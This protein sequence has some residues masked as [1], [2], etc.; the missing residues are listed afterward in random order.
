MAGVMAGD[1]LPLGGAGLGDGPLDTTCDRS[2]VRGG[3]EVRCGSFDFCG[4]LG[5][6]LGSFWARVAV[7][8]GLRS[9]WVGRGFGEGAAA[10]IG[11]LGTSGR[12]VPVLLA[13]GFGATSMG[14]L[15]E[16]AGLC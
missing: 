9:D 2:I 10:G 1:G 14:W 8:S 13:V 15:L 16:A 11:F 7:G 6:G 4:G 3:T 5:A 12:A